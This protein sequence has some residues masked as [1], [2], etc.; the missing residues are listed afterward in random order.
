MINHQRSQEFKEAIVQ[1]MCKPG[2]KSVVELSREI[3]VNVQTLYN[4]RKVMQNKGTEVSQE[5]SPRG[6]NLT[7]KY[8]AVLDSAN[9]SGEDL[10]IWLRKNG[11]QSAHI[12]LWKQECKSMLAHNV[13]K[14]ENKALKL[15]NAELEK[16][17]TRKDKTIAEVTSLLVLKKKAK[18]L[19]LIEED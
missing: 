12:E 15:R 11:L 4:W 13:Y 18:A 8:Q 2:R 3:G 1:K 7:S 9:K 16:E 14:E 5:R 19:G 10:G 17:I 6:W